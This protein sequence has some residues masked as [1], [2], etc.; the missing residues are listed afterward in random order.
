MDIGNL[1][2]NSPTINDD[3]KQEIRETKWED[4]DNDFMQS[5]NIIPPPN[6]ISTNEIILDSKMAS[7][8]ISFMNNNIENILDDERRRKM[9]NREAIISEQASPINTNNKNPYLDNSLLIGTDDMFNEANISSFSKEFDKNNNHNLSHFELDI[10]NTNIR[11]DPNISKSPNIE[12]LKKNK[13]KVSFFSTENEVLS[14]DN[15]SMAS[16]YSSTFDIMKDLEQYGDGSTI[17]TQLNE[18]NYINLEPIIENE[19]ETINNSVNQ[20]LFISEDNIINTTEN[21]QNNSF[22]DLLSNAFDGLINPNSPIN[23]IENIENNSQ[24]DNGNEIDISS[25]FI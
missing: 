25:F 22:S 6:E 21:I 24:K 11:N 15:T 23:N 16:K 20:N 2:I 5:Y 7:K 8:D 13:Y 14:D 4:F 1:D 12:E 18:E 3:V 10:E 9:T 19:E 17:S